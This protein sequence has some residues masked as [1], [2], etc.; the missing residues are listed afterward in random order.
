M[1]NLFNGRF[2]LG[3]QIDSWFDFFMAFIAPMIIV[4]LSI[5]LAY[6]WSIEKLIVALLNGIAIGCCGS[7]L[8]FLIKGK[9]K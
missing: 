6:F 7:L 9:R 2:F 8:I 4:V 1:S 3:V 5:I